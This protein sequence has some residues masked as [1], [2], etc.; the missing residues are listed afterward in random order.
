VLGEIDIHRLDLHHARCRPADLALT[1]RI[2]SDLSAS[3]ADVAL[4]INVNGPEHHEEFRVDVVP[5]LFA[6][7][8]GQDVEE[9]VEPEAALLHFLT[10]LG[11]VQ[12]PGMVGA[13]G[14]GRGIPWP[15]ESEGCPGTG[16]RPYVGQQ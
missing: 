14:L 16:A 1:E 7:D 5:L 11:G 4:T 15:G 12:S 10:P 13:T 2:M 3:P 8:D 6:E 9:L